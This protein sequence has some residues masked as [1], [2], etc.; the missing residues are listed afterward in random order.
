MTLR[1]SG[2]YLNVRQAQMPDSH[3]PCLHSSSHEPAVSSLP[4]VKE[5]AEAP[6]GGHMLSLIQPIVSETRVRC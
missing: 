3:P 6:E 4:R 5:E 2:S 1:L